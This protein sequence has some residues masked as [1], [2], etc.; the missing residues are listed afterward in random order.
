M[1][2]MYLEHP[3]RTAALKTGY[4]SWNQPKSY[5]CEECGEELN[6]EEVYEDFG[7]DYLCEDCLLGLHKKEF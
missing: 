2:D 7:Y 6:P 1:N 5:Y 4:P 3:D